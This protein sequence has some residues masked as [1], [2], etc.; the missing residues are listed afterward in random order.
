MKEFETRRALE[1]DIRGVL[2]ILRTSFEHKYPRLWQ[3]MYRDGH[4]DPLH[5]A[6]EI[7][8]NNHLNH[9]DCTF[10]VAYDASEGASGEEPGERRD[11]PDDNAD[12]FDNLTWGVMALSV[13]RNDRA[14]YLYKTSDLRTYGCLRVLEPAGS[15]G[16]TELDTSDSR[17]RL[18]Y[19]LQDQTQDGQKMCLGYPYL[20]VNALLFWPEFDSDEVSD[21]TIKLLEW[22]VT[23]AERDGWPIWTQIPIEEKE[24]FQQLDFAEVRTFTLDLNHYKPHGSTEDWGTHKWVQMLYFPSQRVRSTN[25]A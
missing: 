7:I 5:Y 9:Q 1:S 24:L 17:V 21:M 19:Q 23:M 13:V 18:L 8:L 16:Q 22:A 20:V 15:V 2:S 4:G 12:I 25:S 6:V 10:I 14:R 3:L 11:G